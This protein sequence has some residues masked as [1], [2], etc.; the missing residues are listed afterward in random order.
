MKDLVQQFITENRLFTKDDKVLVGVSGG[1]DSVALA[2]I[3]KQLGYQIGL[4]HCNFKLRGSESDADEIFVFNLAKQLNVYL[5]KTSF[6][7]EVYAKENGLS[8][9]MAARELRYDW[10]EE[11]R[12]QNEYDYVAIAHNKNDVVE[13]FFINLIRGTGIEGLTGIKS[14][15]DHIVRPFINTSR[16]DID[17][18]INSQSFNF[19][20]DSSNASTKYLRNQI[21]HNII[22]EFKAISKDFDETM[23]GNMERIRQVNEIYKREIEFKKSKLFIQLT[24]KIKVNIERLSLLEPLNTYLYEFLKSYGFSLSTIK[25]IAASIHGESGKQFFSKT[26]V[27]TKDREELII[28]E[29][30]QKPKE[31][32]FF[33]EDTQHILEPQNIKIEIVSNHKDF[34]I[35]KSS[36]IGALDLE[37]ITFPLLLRP[38]KNGDYFT[39]LGMNRMKKVSDFLIDTKVSLPDK[40]QTYI[41][42]TKNEIAWIVGQRID[43]R[44]KITAETKRILLLTLKP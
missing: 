32:V 38:W 3:L 10:F 14:L 30:Q 23:M 11:I 5:Y 21:R 2:H 6:N 36:L 16:D 43:D 37:K 22:P 8:I 33:G 18:Y 25:D 41:V 9:Q 17:K 27:V 13:T 34:K 29:I 1:V 19:R 35:P 42:Q 28:E 40:D 20:E 26:H 12:T 24:D 15:K 4:A 31:E 44:F 7:T 39:P